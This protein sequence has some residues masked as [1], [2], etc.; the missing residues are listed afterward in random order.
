MFAREYD[1]T[2]QGLQGSV[3]E[4]LEPGR[5]TRSQEPRTLYALPLMGTQDC[6]RV[7][8]RCN[9]VCASFFKIKNQFSGFL[10]FSREEFEN[11]YLFIKMI[12]IDWCQNFSILCKTKK[13]MILICI[14][15]NTRMLNMFLVSAFQ[16]SIP[17]YFVILSP[18]ENYS[19]YFFEDY[20][21]FE[22]HLL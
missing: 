11:I 21:A 12:L 8:V 7:F 17:K 2:R 1:G 18:L 13:H 22:I 15:E 3:P 16:D 6:I 19:R 9:T 5:I 14:F 4:N 20:S 10:N